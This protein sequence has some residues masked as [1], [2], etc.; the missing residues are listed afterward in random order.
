MRASSFLLGSMV[1]AAAAIYFMR[2]GKFMMST[3]MTK[4]SDSIGQAIGNGFA[5]MNAM[6]KNGKM[7]QSHKE[8]ESTMHGK[9]HNQGMDKINE[10]INDDPSVKH[11]VQEILK[12]N[13]AGTAA[14]QSFQ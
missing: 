10:L 11:Q 9:S 8:D 5:A 3:T 13:S 1:G 2:G 7:H 12:E 14:S 6:G 4:T